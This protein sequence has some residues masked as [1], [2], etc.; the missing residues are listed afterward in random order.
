MTLTV[1]KVKEVQASIRGRV[2]QEA[3]EL[4]K[5]EKQAKRALKRKL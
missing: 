5:D 3:N 2:N 4:S 1:E